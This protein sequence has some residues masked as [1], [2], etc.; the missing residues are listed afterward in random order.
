MPNSDVLAVLS[1]MRGEIN[2]T[3]LD[4]QKRLTRVET[5]T[6]SLVGNGQPGRVGKLEDEVDD[7]KYKS[8]KQLG[9]LAGVV[10]T[11]EVGWH[12]IEHFFL[13]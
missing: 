5:H 10:A 2:T 7:M 12:A 6:E 11:L 3:L 9:W 1:D 13:K 8:A 4:I